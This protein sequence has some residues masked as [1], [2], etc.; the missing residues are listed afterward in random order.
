MA[1]HKG[2]PGRPAPAL[3]EQAPFSTA[4]PNNRPRETTAGPVKGFG[5][6]SVFNENW[7]ILKVFLV[8]MAVSIGL[9]GI[10]VWKFLITAE[11]LDKQFGLSRHVRAEIM[12]EVDSGYSRT[13]TFRPDDATSENTLPFYAEADQHTKISIEAHTTG[14]DPAK[15]AALVQVDGDRW[16]EGDGSYHTPGLVLLKLRPDLP[17]GSFHQARLVVR[18]VPEGGAV[19]VTCVVLV[20]NVVAETR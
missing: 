18:Q 2:G 13:F 9:I 6:I 5:V 8:A 19:V 16:A 1:H 7:Q 11:F 17:T 15:V 14:G 20:Y 10:P 12:K 3:Q 4:P